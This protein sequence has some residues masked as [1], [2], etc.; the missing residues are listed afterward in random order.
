MTSRPPR[1][2]L[3]APIPLDMPM[4]AYAALLRAVNVGGTG[5]MPMAQ[6][7]AMCEA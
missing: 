4:P 7:Q 5:K 1:G 6:L 3:D 2:R